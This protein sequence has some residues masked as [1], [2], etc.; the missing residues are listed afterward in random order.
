METLTDRLCLLLYLSPANCLCLLLY[1]SFADCLR[2]LL[3]FCSADCRCLLLYFC[4]ADCR[5]LLLYLTPADWFC[6]C[7]LLYYNMDQHGTCTHY[8]LCL[9]ALIHLGL[10]CMVWQGE[11]CLRTCVSHIWR[12]S[13][14]SLLR[15][16]LQGTS[17]ELGGRRSM[18]R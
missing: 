2:L 11:S 15:Q 12:W 9:N 3:Y 16:W 10:E 13:D 14:L 4:S 1:S 17:C 7:L 6:L 18:G 8:F 5:C